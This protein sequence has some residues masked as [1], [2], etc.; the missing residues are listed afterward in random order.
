MGRGA[1]RLDFAAVLP[2]QA[3]ANSGAGAFLF[4]GGCLSGSVLRKSVSAR[5]GH[6]RSPGTEIPGDRQPDA[7]ALAREKG[8]LPETGGFD[9]VFQR[10]RVGAESFAALVHDEQND[11]RRCICASTGFF[12]IPGPIFRT[13]SGTWSRSAASWKSGRS[14]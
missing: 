5:N 4:F 11:R 2:M 13:R 1:G 14:C 12:P 10:L 7:D 6:R 9:V 8:G 3:S